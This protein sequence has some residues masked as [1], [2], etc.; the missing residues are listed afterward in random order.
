MRFALFRQLSYNIENMLVREAPTVDESRL[1][2][3]TMTIVMIIWWWWY[4]G[5][6]PC[7]VHC[8]NSSANYAGNS[9]SS[10]S[11][12]FAALTTQLFVVLKPTIWGHEGAKARCDNAGKL[13]CL[14]CLLWKSGSLA[15]YFSKVVSRDDD[16]SGSRHTHTW[17]W[18][19]M[20]IATTATADGYIPSRPRGLS[21]QGLPLNCYT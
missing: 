7:L 17:L 13:N 11:V 6:A 4:C 10:A 5:V 14:S 15:E 3:M 16:V 18:L 8:G 1:M 20:S 21:Q 12:Y 9:I 2:T 19:T